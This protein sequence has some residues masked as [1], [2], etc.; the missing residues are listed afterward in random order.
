METGKKHWW[1]REIPFFVVSSER[2]EQK[3]QGKMTLKSQLHL[4][5]KKLRK[6]NDS[7]PGG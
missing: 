5:F 2:K 6:G 4:G 7:K 3:A 1:K